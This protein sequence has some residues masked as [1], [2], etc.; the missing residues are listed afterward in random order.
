MLC[1]MSQSCK[2]HKKSG[3]SSVA[4]SSRGFAAPAASDEQQQC[5]QHSQRHHSSYHSACRCIRVIGTAALIL[6]RKLGRN[7]YK[8]SAAGFCNC[9]R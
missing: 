6:G 4:Y 2:L 9:T 5:S 8:G 3:P 7:W 1:S